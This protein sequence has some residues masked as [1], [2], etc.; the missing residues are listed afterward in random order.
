MSYFP[1]F[2]D[3]AGR[4]GLI[5]GGGTVAARKVEKLL[6]YGPRL[7]LCAPDISPE[8]KKLPELRL[9][10][11]SFE[12]ELLEG[13]D[14]VI[15]ATA[16]RALNHRVAALCKQ[17]N[18]PVNVVDDREESSFLFPALVKRGELSIGISTGGCS[19]SAAIH[20]KR[21]ISA[22]IPENFGEILI[23]LDSLRRPVMELLPEDER[24]RGALLS[25]FFQACL[26]KGGPLDEEETARIMDKIREERQ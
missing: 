18:I 8:L 24:A 23:F 22:L 17:R 9:L 10:R 14:F 26:Q 6:P 2:I 4:E 25:R 21:E 20:W 7:T 13:K 16:D 12:A 5:I 11:R 15:A 19:P 1:L 3:L